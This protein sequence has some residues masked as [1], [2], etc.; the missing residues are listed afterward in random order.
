M[1]FILSNYKRNPMEFLK[2]YGFKYDINQFMWCLTCIYKNIEIYI[3]IDNNSTELVIDIVNNTNNEKNIY[4]QKIPKYISEKLKYQN[5]F[6]YISFIENA[7][8][9][10]LSNWNI[11]C[12]EITF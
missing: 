9:R 1:S 2:D 5:F 7:C 11:D 4:V 3:R 6:D 8:L 10:A 12:N